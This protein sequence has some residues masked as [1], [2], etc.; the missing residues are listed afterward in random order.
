ML[1]IGIDPGTHHL[2]WGLVRRQGN[3]LVHVAHGVV[4]PR[5]DAPL[6][7]RLCEIDDALAEVLSEYRPAAGAVETLFFYK[8][9][10]AAAKLGHAR[11][12]V[13]LVLAKAGLPIA[14]YQPAR[15]KRALTGRGQAGKPQVAQMVRA[16][17]GLDAVP[18]ADAADALAVAVT[19]LR[20]GALPSA[21]EA[22]LQGHGPT[23]RDRA[24]IR[25]LL[26]K[27]SRSIG[28]RRGDR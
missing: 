9:A 25:L 12:V 4:S 21:I 26:Q 28:N 8:D 24:N 7:Q 18:R 5:T 10:Q 11:G 15:I 27:S 19:H 1:V 13:L 3:H 2:G 16:V 17:L 20:I 14:E 22:S 6:A 23:A